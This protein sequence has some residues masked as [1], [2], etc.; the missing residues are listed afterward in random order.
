LQLLTTS[1]KTYFAGGMREDS[2]ATA[3]I[4]AADNIGAK[5]QKISGV[6]TSRATDELTDDQMS[7]LYE[8]ANKN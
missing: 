7:T 5:T 6:G 4:G 3:A 8:T 1:I 2:R